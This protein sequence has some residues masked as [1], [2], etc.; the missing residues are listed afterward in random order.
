MRKLK[1]IIAFVNNQETL[2]SRK[3]SILYR[4]IPV[5]ISKY[6][7]PEFLLAVQDR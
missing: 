4:D 3:A 1:L 5:I 6:Q 7:S 2:P